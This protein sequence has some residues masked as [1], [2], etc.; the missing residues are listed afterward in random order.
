MLNAHLDSDHE[1]IKAMLTMDG[2]V[3]DECGP[4]DDR[5]DA[6]YAAERAIRASSDD[7]LTIHNAVRSL[8]GEAL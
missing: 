6:Y 1:G 4:F 8:Y 5:E 3:I 7:A 2:E